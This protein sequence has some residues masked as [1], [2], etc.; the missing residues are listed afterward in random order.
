MTGSCVAGSCVTGQLC[1]GR[2]CRRRQLCDGLVGVDP[3]GKR[4]KEKSEKK[5]E[6]RVTKAKKE[7]KKE[8]NGMCDGR[9]TT[10]NVTVFFQFFS[11]RAALK[12]EKKFWPPK[13][14]LK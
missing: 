5:K 13:K 8:R 3:Q 10:Y 9:I 14:K 6:K 2:L 1:D 12:N 11:R 4:K 7:R